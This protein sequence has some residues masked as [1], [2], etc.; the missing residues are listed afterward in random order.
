[1][2][3]VAATMLEGGNA[4]EELDTLMQADDM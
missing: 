1:M 3:T 4:D 2:E